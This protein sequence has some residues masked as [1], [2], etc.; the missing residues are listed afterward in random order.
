MILNLIC[1]IQYQ[2]E[3]R[4]AHHDPVI[5]LAEDGQIGVVIQ[6]DIEFLSSLPGIWVADA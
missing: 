3:Q 5:A 4:H 1:D 2:G 6:I